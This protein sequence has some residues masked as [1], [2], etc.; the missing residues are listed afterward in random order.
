MSF[1]INNW[2]LVV[3]A[4]GSGLLLVL[5]MLQGS[6]GA[7]IGVTDAVQIMNRDKAMVIDVCQ[8]EEFAQAHV[9]QAINLPLAQIATQLQSVAKDKSRPL[10]FVCA[11]GARSL[12]AM[13]EAKKL[14][15]E[16]VY[17]LQGGL[18]AWKE[19]NLPVSKA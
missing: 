10:I 9:R 8:P 19:A 4:L 12:R 11:A 17:S 14:G 18:K 6:A 7:G 1:L 16:Q 13:S 3:L 15:Y 5:P 2:L